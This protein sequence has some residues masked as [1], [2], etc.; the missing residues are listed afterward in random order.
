MAADNYARSLRDLQRD[1]EAKA[2]MRKI[3]LVARRVLGDKDRLTLRMRMNY[4]TAL[5]EDPAAT[6]E[7]LREAVTTLEETS[8]TARRILGS[9]HPTTKTIEWRLG[10]ARTVLR[11]REDG[12]KVKFV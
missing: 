11:A 7:D 12:K 4:A 6:L 1:K 10:Q 2:L 9:E 5:Y 8:R 3:I